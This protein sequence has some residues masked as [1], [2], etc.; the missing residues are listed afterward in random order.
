MI[1]HLDGD[2]EHLWAGGLPVGVFD[3]ANYD[4]QSFRL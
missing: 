3:G 1:L 2:I 4:A